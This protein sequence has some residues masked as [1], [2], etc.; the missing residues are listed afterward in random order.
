[1]L[2]TERRHEYSARVDSRHADNQTGK[3]IKISQHG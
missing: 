3:E 1:M 2:E